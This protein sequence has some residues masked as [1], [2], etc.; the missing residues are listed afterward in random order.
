MTKYQSNRQSR[1]YYF[2]CVKGILILAVVFGHILPVKSI[3]HVF[4][5]SWHIPCFFIVNGILLKRTSFKQRALMGKQGIL[6]RGIRKLLIPYFVWG[7][8]LLL[9]RWIA[10]NFDIS[11]LRWQLIDLF[12]FCGIGATWF[13]PCL[14]LSQLILW[15]MIRVS[16]LEKKHSELVLLL[17]GVVLCLTGIFVEADFPNVIVLRRSM[18]GSFFCICGWLL[19]DKL[20]VL[21]GNTKRFTRICTSLILCAA[22]VVF[23]YMTGK[24]EAALNTLQFGVPVTYVLNALLGSAMIL[25]IVTCF[26]EKGILVRLLSFYGKNSLTVMG[27]HQPLMLAIQIPVVE[28]YCMNFL[29]FIIVS[30][31]EAPIIILYQIIKNKNTRIM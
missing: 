30:A 27:S 8:I 19:S 4:L 28:R 7:S 17:E 3:L 10:S 25:A 24:N 6:I 23:F 31:I 1:S 20:T 18:V 5:Y 29:Y 22:S 11:V 21:Q 14:Y 26:D 9:F 13:L 15:I 16:L 12:S 2:D